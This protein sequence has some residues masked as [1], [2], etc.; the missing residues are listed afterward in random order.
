M[1]EK[2]QIKYDLFEHE[3]VVTSQEAADVR[4]EFA[5]DQ[6]TKALIV[7]LYTDRSDEFV[8]LVVPGDTEFDKEKVL[9]VTHAKRMRFA[10]E[11]EIAKITA[12]VPIGGIPP[13]GN[14]F[15]IR[16]IVD[17]SIKKKDQIVFNAGAK[18]V[19]IAVTPAAY[20]SLGDFV[21][22]QIT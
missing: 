8:M 4:D 19:S 10:N 15:D 22:A 14:L 5:K 18:T 7:K 3:P 17:T 9:E 13:L 16:T 20:E 1:F 11:D 12:G 6:G 2:K 21:F